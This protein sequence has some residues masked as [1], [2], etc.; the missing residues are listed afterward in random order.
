MGLNLHEDSYSIC[1]PSTHTSSLNSGSSFNDNQKITKAVIIAA[2]NGSRLEGYQNSCPKPLV[3][4]G[5]MPLLQRVILSA[6]RI[7]ITEFVIVLGYQAARIRKTINSK[8]LGVKITWVRNLDWRK[9]NGVS[10]LKAEKFVD[11][12]FLL[13]MSDHVF[14]VNILEKLK[15]VQLGKECGLLCVDYALNTVH[16]LD[17]ATKV[18][19]VDNQLLDLG[20]SLT[21][22]NAIDVGIFIHTPLI[23][24]ALRRSQEQGDYSLSGGVRVLAEE[25]RMCTFNIGDSFWQDVDTIPDIRNAERLLLRATRSSRDGIVAKRLNRRVSNRISKWLIKTPVTPNQISLFNLF[26]M[27]F[28]AW[29]I[30]FGKPLNTIIGGII[31]QLTSILDGCDG[32]V[33]QIKLKDSKFGAFVDTV[34]DQISYIVFIIGATIGAYNATND[35]VVFWV[36]G[37]SLALIAVALRFSL[38]YIKK[39]G[40]T[41]LKDFDQDIGSFKYPNQQV[42]YLKFFGIIHQL[43]RRDAWSFAGF[44]IMLGGSITVFFWGL[45]AVLNML[46]VGIIITAG[47]LLS[48]RHGVNAFSPIKKLYNQFSRWFSSP[49]IELQP[50]NKISE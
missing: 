9:P 12:R 46:G 21:D 18:R 33:A 47:T 27:I 42:W 14:N 35:T 3:K 41:S 32:E 19:T 43:G 29:F 20:K 44:L 23:F 30:A 38:L 22:F 10:V 28:G 8:K 25:G 49:E 34:T 13:F 4:V 1:T 7:G 40:S 2:G 17:D 24:D 11:G 39:K 16:N 5:G 36:A 37:F 6:K 26:L 48:Q 45:M 15:S 31:F 50:E